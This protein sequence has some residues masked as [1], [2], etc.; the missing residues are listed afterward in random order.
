MSNKSN[1]KG[2]LTLMGYLLFILGFLSIL[3][4]MVGLQLKILK[5]ISSIGPGNGII[6]KLIMLF[7]G[8]IIMYF[9]KFPP[10]EEDE[11][12]NF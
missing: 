11:K 1:K 12:F 8:L 10:E 4:S 7:G 9:S 5:W 2:I 3:L 6:V